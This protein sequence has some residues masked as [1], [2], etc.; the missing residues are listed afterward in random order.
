MVAV[1]SRQK[2]KNERRH[3]HLSSCVWFYYYCYYYYCYCYCYYCFC[4]G[5]RQCSLGCDEVAIKVPCGTVLQSYTH[6]TEPWA[7]ETSVTGKVL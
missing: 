4:Y 3:N 5:N 6:T 1:S 7:E 2:G